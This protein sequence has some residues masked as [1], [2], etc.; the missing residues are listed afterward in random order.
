VSKF[1]YWVPFQKVDK[2]KHTVAGYAS[3]ETEDSQGEITSR[4]ALEQALPDYMKF[5]NIRE[6]HDP[7]KAAGVAQEAEMTDQGLLLT[8]KIVDKDAWE[9]V[10]EGVYK[11]FSIGG[12]KIEKL[13]KVIT[14]IALNE[15][16]IVDRPANPDCVFEVYKADGS[17]DDKEDADPTTIQSLIFD[18][19]KFTE[20]EAKAWAKDHDFKNSDVDVTT[21]SIRLRQKD[22]GAFKDGSFRTIPLKTGVKAVIGK[23][24]DTKKTE[25]GET[26]M[27]EKK[28]AALTKV[29]SALKKAMW[30]VGELASIIDRLKM[31]ADSVKWEEAMEADP[32]SKLPALL[33]DA[34]KNL[35]SV[36]LEMTAEEVAEYVALTAPIQTPA[37]TAPVE[38][39]A[40]ADS[41]KECESSAKEAEARKEALKKYSELRG[42]EDAKKE[43]EDAFKELCDAMGFKASEEK[44]GTA[45]DQKEDTKKEDAAK[46]DA[47]KAK[48]KKEAEDAAKAKKEAEDAAKIKK[49]DVKK[50]D[51]PVDLKKSVDLMA[52]LQDQ[53]QGLQDRIVKMEQ[54]PVPTKAFAGPGTITMEKSQDAGGASTRITE[55]ELDEILKKGD[56]LE[57]IKQVHKGRL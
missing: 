33:H 6:Q 31:L 35:G 57:T 54:Q 24:K 49:E 11:G 36:L 38:N 4:E 44:P 9:K 45:S 14:K 34:V 23:L 56:V 28:K 37:T 15:I 43:A 13:G 39:T 22:P 40:K 19:E 51:E 8:A 21:D 32:A 48:A 27:D 53:I 7:H 41:C 50:T 26:T 18:K 52:A 29:D 20:A 47:K 2:E 1:F 30:S 42:K 10:L 25:K 5:A 46:E 16:S 17:K 12:K 3:T 55:A